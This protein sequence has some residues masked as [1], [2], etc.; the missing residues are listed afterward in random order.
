LVTKIKPQDVSQAD[1]Q[2]VKMIKQI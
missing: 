1:K 2:K